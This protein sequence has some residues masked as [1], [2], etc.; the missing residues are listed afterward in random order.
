MET[1]VDFICNYI[2]FIVIT[3]YESFLFFVIIICELLLNVQLLN[4][5][6]F[7]IFCKNV[8]FYEI[9]IISEVVIVLTWVPFSFEGTFAVYYVIVSS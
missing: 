3:I 1:Q 7:N 6:S 5:R 2:I 8:F 4:F 9:D